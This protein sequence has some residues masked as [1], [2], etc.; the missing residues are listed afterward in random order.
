MGEKLNRIEWIDAL[1]GFAIFCVTLGHLGCNIFLEKHI[2]SFHMFLFFFLSGYLD[3]IEN[4]SF[5]Q[6]LLKKIKRILIPFISWNLISNLVAILMGNSLVE[7]I[8]TTFL[9]KGEICWNAPIW[10]LLTIFLTQILY[11]VLKKFFNLNDIIIMLFSFFLWIAFSQKNIL[12]KLNLIPMSLL[13]YVLGA[14]AQRKMQNGIGQYLQK[15][16]AMI[17]CIVFV[18][19]AFINI[20][21]GVIHNVRIVYTKSVFGNVF[22]CLLAAISGIAFYV[23]SFQLFDFLGNNKLLNYLGRN[24]LIIMASQFYFFNLYDAFAGFNV[25]LL[26]NTLKAF[27][28]SIGTIAIICFITNTINYIGKRSKIIKNISG[29]FGI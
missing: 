24:S 26:R 14:Y 16:H 18:V 17:V 11:F 10:F 20:Y 12:L 9:L 19:L 23:L 21:F 15:R 28:M 13:F 1:K 4:L 25:H 29:W 27:V 22:Y 7:V 2:Y 6:Y 5:K 3:K 8:N